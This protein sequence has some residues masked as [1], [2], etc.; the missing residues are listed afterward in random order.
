[1]KLS[2]LSSAILVASG[3]LVSACSQQSTDTPNNQQAK[4]DAT[5]YAMQNIDEQRLDIYTEV[6]LTSDL[7]HLNDNQ[8]KMIGVLI[9]ASKIMDNLFWKQAF[10]EDKATFLSRIQ[11]P[12]VRRFAD[13]N[14]GPW[15]RLDGDKVFLSGFSEKS[16]GAQFYPHDMTKEELNNA[17]FKDKQGLYSM[18]KRD[19]QGNLVSTA[20][21]TEFRAELEEAAKLLRQASNL[22]VDKDFANYLNLR[23]DALLN[24]SYQPSDF[25]WMDMKN[26]P[27]DVVIG[28]IETYE[29]QLFGYRSAFE[30]YVLVKDL[31]WSERLAKFAAFLPELQTGLPVAQK[32]KQ[33][34]PGSDADLNAYDVVYYAGHSNAGSKTIAINLPNDEQVQL[35]KGTRRLQLKNAM[36]AKFDKILV[37]IADQLIVPEQRKHIT[38]DAFFANTMFHEVA[39]GLGI[40]NTITGKGTVRQSLQEHASAI[41]EGKADILGLYMVEQLLKK[42]EITEGTL[43]DYYVTFMAGIFRSVRFGASSAH[44]K[45]NMIRFNFFKQEGAFSKNAQGLYQVDMEKMGAAMAKLSNLILTLQGDGDYQKVDA[46]IATHGDI[47]AELQADLAKLAKASIPVDVTFNQGKSVLGL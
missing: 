7:S 8:K 34:V 19:Q 5:N 26:N 18:V 37:P 31:A 39:H 41:E 43:E 45:A 13:I 23:A 3:L 4:A 2:K 11:D 42:G 1:M 35:E 36:R 16:P 29:D 22:A 15:D 24:N 27:I 32:Y 17:D 25:A 28:P 38:F 21:A 20:Y 40:K 33:E 9:D 10:G 14:Y 6:T 12:N 46:L 44:G 30:S 47:K